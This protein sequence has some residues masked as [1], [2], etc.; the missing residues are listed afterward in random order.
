MTLTLTQT[1]REMDIAEYSVKIEL[2]SG[3]LCTKNYTR[4]N[5]VHPVFMTLIMVLRAYRDV[6]IH[7]KTNSKPLATE[8]NATVQNPN[9]S[10]LSHLKTVI[11]RNNLDVTIE[12]VA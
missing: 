1:I 2:P 10:L 8:Y 3:E 6:A 4:S 9:A 7:V 12:Y 11:A 5:E